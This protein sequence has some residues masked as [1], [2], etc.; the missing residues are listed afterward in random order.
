MPHDFFAAPDSDVSP[1]RPSPDFPLDPALQAAVCTRGVPVVLYFSSLVQ[2]RVKVRIPAESPAGLPAE[3][4][5]N[6]KSRLGGLSS[7]IAGEVATGLLM[8]T[9]AIQSRVGTLNV[10]LDVIHAGASNHL[11]HGL[12]SVTPYVVGFYDHHGQAWYRCVGADTPNPNRAATMSRQTAL[13]ILAQISYAHPAL[14]CF[15]RPA[16]QVRE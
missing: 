6:L 2:T 8:A 5:F 1:D 13:R 7:A 4:E 11:A 3:S 16:D 12:D 14:G 15:M 10:A 9:T